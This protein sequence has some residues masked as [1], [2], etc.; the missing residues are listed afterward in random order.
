MKI[1]TA[2][3]LVAS[4]AVPTLR[5]TVGSGV[6]DGSGTWDNSTTNWTGDAGATRIAWVPGDKAQ[7]GGGTNGAGSNVVAVSGTVVADEVIIDAPFSGTSYSLTGGT[8]NL[9]GTARVKNSVALATNTT[10]TGT[11]G[12]KKAGAGTLTMNG[13]MAFSGK[14]AVDDGTFLLN[15][16]PPSTSRWEFSA[17]TGAALTT[18]GSKTIGSLH[19]GNS[20]VNNFVT[21]NNIE[22][23][24]G[25]DNTTDGVFVGKIT[26]STGN[27]TLT[28]TGTGTQTLTGNH[29]FGSLGILKVQGG[30]L[31]STGTQSGTLD[32]II[33]NSGATLTIGSAAVDHIITGFTNGTLNIG[34]AF[35]IAGTALL[36][37]NANSATATINILSGGTY[38]QNGATCVLSN[39]AAGVTQTAVMNIAA[40]GTFALSSSGT[41]FGIAS[42]SLSAGTVNHEGSVASARDINGSVG[43]STWNFNGGGLRSE[44]SSATFFQ[45]MTRCNIRN[46]GAL[47]NTNGYNSTVAQPL[48]HSNIG[49]DNATDGGVLKIGAGTLTLSGANTYTGTTTVNGGTLLISGATALGTGAGTVNSGGTLTY[50]VNTTGTRTVIVNTGGVINKGGFTHT[51]TTFVNAGGTINA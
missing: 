40:G 42:G 24:I 6:L 16:S 49:G 4:A 23:T 1:H 8:I 30:T 5:W 44:F 38:T 12:F 27:L 20:S 47:F 25:A 31:I 48:L 43:T 13:A 51:G 14:I 41:A 11:A 45:G 19:G 34:G 46:N 9:T 3:L 2:L 37:Q 22:I 29:N 15:V 10:F 18:G 35:S 39:A 21:S 28:K 33:I 26:A 50:S 7:I 17:A 32:E 36:G